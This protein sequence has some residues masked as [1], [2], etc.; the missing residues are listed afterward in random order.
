MKVILLRDVAKI[1]RRGQVVELPDGYAQNQ[2][3]PKK[4]AE[5][6]TPVNLK[7]IANLDAT[8]KAHKAAEQTEF[9]TAVAEL[10]KN[11]LVLKGD[12]NAQGHMFKAVHE[13]DIVAAAS[14]A[15]VRLEKRA[16]YIASP[17]KS[18]GKHTIELRHGAE[19]AQCEIEVISKT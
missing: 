9:A 18:L 11:R 10:T 2:L 6:A 19:K 8:T 17:I 16:V 1:G 13:D 4:W 3:I 7:R 12:A 15:G 14:L 5:P